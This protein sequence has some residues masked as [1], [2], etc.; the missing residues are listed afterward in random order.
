MCDDKKEKQYA[1]HASFD[2]DYDRAAKRISDSIP[3]DDLL[4]RYLPKEKDND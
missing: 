2:E 3:E 4:E 1:P